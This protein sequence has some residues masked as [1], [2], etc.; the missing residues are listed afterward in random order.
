MK[1]D[2]ES[3][4]V[5]LFKE[6]I[7]VFFSIKENPIVLEEVGLGFGIADLVISE[8]NFSDI[9]LDREPLNSIDINIYKIIERKKKVTIDSVSETTRCNKRQINESLDKLIK[10][11]FIEKR[12]SYYVFT[13]KY[14]LSFK[15][16]IA[17]EAKLKNW[18]RALMQAYRYKWFADYSYVVLDHAY[19]K[20]AIENIDMFKRYNIGLISVSFEGEIFKHN[21][22]RRE[23][24]LDPKMQILLSETLIYS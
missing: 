1:F 24:P 23:K 9:E 20:V 5:S 19:I 21:I 7:D 6:K 17:I 14:E 18:K 11:N 13:N 22:P 16:S 2:T 4:L 8:L 3:G 10:G 15:K 12:D